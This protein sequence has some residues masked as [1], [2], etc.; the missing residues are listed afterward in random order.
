M[1]PELQELINSITPADPGVIK[2]ANIRQALLTKPPG[3]LGRL[4]EISVRLAGI[5]GNTRPVVN[6][7]SLVIAAGDH[8]VVAQGVTAYP[9]EITGQMVLNFLAGG[10]GRDGDGPHS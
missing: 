4:E 3:S 6:G 5:F 7:R 1:N 8:G 10:G 9:Q 2:R